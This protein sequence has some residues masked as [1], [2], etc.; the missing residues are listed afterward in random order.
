MSKPVGSLPVPPACWMHKQRSEKTD[1][2]F[3]SALRTKGD[4]SRRWI[5]IEGTSIC[6]GK[7]RGTKEKV[8]PFEVIRAVQR[9]PAAKVAGAPDVF[10]NFAWEMTLTDKIVAFVCESAETRDQ[11]VSYMTAVLDAMSGA[12]GG[13]PSSASGGG[14]AASSPATVASAG[15]NSGGGTTMSARMADS[16]SNLARGADRD[17]VVGDDEAGGATARKSAD[18]LKNLVG[19]S[20][21]ADDLDLGGAASIDFDDDFLDSDMEDDDAVERERA[22]RF[23]GGEDA[24]AEGGGGLNAE[25]MEARYRKFLLPI[26]QRSFNH[27]A[28]RLDTYKDF[29]AKWDDVVAD[30]VFS[31]TMEKIGKKDRGAE[32]DIFVT[33][34]HLFLFSKGNMFGRIADPRV[35]DLDQI[36][37]V[38]ESK[39]D[40]SLFA[41]II[42]SF[43]DL[44]L[45]VTSASS[46]VGGTEVEVKHQLIAHLYAGS[47]RLAGDTRPFIFRESENIKSLIRRSED[48]NHLPLE[49]GAFDRLG[50]AL[51][52]QLYPIFRVN[53]D[54]VVHFSGYVQRTNAQKSQSARI[55]AITDSAVYLTPT[56]A[57]R[58]NSRTGLS[59]IRRIVY[60]DDA[61]ELLLVNAD[62]DVL[63]TAKNKAELDLIV[64]V[65][66]DVAVPR[67]GGGAAARSALR[68][69]PGKQLFSGARLMEAKRIEDHLQRGIQGTEQ[70]LRKGMKLSQRMLQHTLRLG[71][72]GATKLGMGVKSIGKGS[73]GILKTGITELGELVVDNRISAGILGA[74][75]GAAGQVLGLQ[76]RIVFDMITSLEDE[77]ATVDAAAFYRKAT[78]AAGGR[79]VTLPGAAKPKAPPP[80]TDPGT[81]SRQLVAAAAQPPAAAPTPTP[82]GAIEP[83]DPVG[84]QKTSVT[85]R[86]GRVLFSC[87]CRI[88]NITAHIDTTRS[89]D[90]ILC[91]ADNGLYV[92]DDPHSKNRSGLRKIAA[93]FTSSQN[94]DVVES[95]TWSELGGIIRCVHPVDD[96]IIGVLYEENRTSGD[97]MFRLP[98][99]RVTDRFLCYASVQHWR[100]HPCSAGSSNHDDDDED[101]FNVRLPKLFTC[102]HAET[103]K[104]ALKKT[105]FDAP[106][107]I[108]LIAEGQGDQLRLGGESDVADIMRQYGDRFVTFSGLGRQL[109]ASAIRGGA[110]ASTETKRKKKKKKKEGDD[111]AGDGEDA[112]S[113]HDPI[114]KPC[115]VLVTNAAVYVVKPSFELDRR[116]DVNAI[117]RITISRDEADTLLLH[118]KTEYDVFLRMPGRMQELIDR[119]QDSRLAWSSYP[120]ELAIAERTRASLQRISQRRQRERQHAASGSRRFPSAVNL[121]SL[122]ALAAPPAKEPFLIP[123]AR[124]GG[125]SGDAATA[126]GSKVSGAAAGLMALGKLEKPANFDEIERSRRGP[127]QIEQTYRAWCSKELKKA[128]ASEGISEDGELQTAPGE[129]GTVVATINARLAPHEGEALRRERRVAALMTQLKRAYRIG[130]RDMP[131]V[132]QV[133]KEISLHD[134]RE[135]VSERLYR[136]L[137]EDD[138]EAY[139]DAVAASFDLRDGL[140]RLLDS[141][142]DDV[143]AMK[144]RHDV[145][146]RIVK[147]IALD[148]LESRLHDIA[149]LFLQA[150][151]CNVR[152]D[153]LDHLRL[154]VDRLLQRERLTQQIQSLRRVSD[155]STD[156][157]AVW[158]AAAERLGVP[159][160]VRG[161]I[162]VVGS[163]LIRW[164]ETAL[165]NAIASADPHTIEATMA[166]V[167]REP[168][169]A[170]GAQEAL[171]AAQHS[172]DL[173]RQH[174]ALITRVREMCVD[175]SSRM[176]DMTPEALRL[177]HE[178]LRGLVPKFPADTP[179]FQRPRATVLLHLGKAEHL[180]SSAEQ[181]R[182]ADEAE[183]SVMAAYAKQ[184]ELAAA[185]QQRAQ[186]QA[187]QEEADRQSAK[188][189]DRLLNIASRS[190]KYAFSVRQQVANEDTAGAH[191]SLNAIEQLSSDLAGAVDAL[192]PQEKQDLKAE[193]EKAHNT[194]RSSS[195][196]CQALM[197]KAAQAK[198]K[199]QM[200]PELAAAVRELRTQDVIQYLQK[201]QGTLPVDLIDSVKEALHREAAQAKWVAGLHHGI[202][203]AVALRSVDLLRA[204]LDIAKQKSYSDAAVH[205][206]REW[207]DAQVAAMNNAAGAAAA[208]ASPAV[209]GGSPQA[210]PPPQAALPPPAEVPKPAV[211]PLMHP[212]TTTTGKGACVLALHS[213]VV[214]LVTFPR[215]TVSQRVKGA[216]TTPDD[217]A[218]V[219]A[220][221]DAWIAALCH[222]AKPQGIFRKTDRSLADII[223]FMGE[224]KRGGD[225]VAPF[226]FYVTSE[227]ERIRKLN[228]PHGLTSAQVFVRFLMSK[229]D[230]ERLVEEIARF[231]PKE[232]DGLYF[233][234]ALMRAVAESERKDVRLLAKML[235]QIDV[236]FGL[237]DKVD[238]AVLGSRQT[239]VAGTGGATATNSAS[240]VLIDAVSKGPGATA[241]GTKALPSDLG[242]LKAAILDH[243]DDSRYLQAAGVIVF[244]QLRRAVSSLSALVTAEMR[245]LGDRPGPT[246]LYAFFDENHNKSIGVFARSNLCAA[247]IVCLG[248]GFRPTHM[249][250]ASRHLWDLFE[251]GAERLKESARGLGGVAVPDMIDMVRNLTE[252]HE[253]GPASPSHSAASRGGGGGPHQ[254]LARLS[255][256]ELNDVRVRMVLCHA[257]NHKSLEALFTTLF[258]AS[259][260]S[261]AFL[262]KFYVYDG[263]LMFNAAMRGEFDKVVRQLAKIP[264]VLNVDA[265]IW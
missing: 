241:A 8:I 206:A 242:G 102:D 110:E 2:G 10:V 37:G 105:A 145:T 19:G 81:S 40:A 155:L 235:T 62:I 160:A 49:Q 98:N 247:L 11:W 9:I 159:V 196:L 198:Q 161:S 172:L 209:E 101:R 264:F 16:S 222:R 56:S 71:L 255:S 45:R 55:F 13:V 246:A 165:S 34:K 89:E 44:L 249:L 217:T 133:K 1:G 225:V 130:C 157:R 253:R 52:S 238:A 18:E 239:S 252:V 58:I 99:G 236:S 114:T 168:E 6:Y 84:I 194:L 60:D 30:V 73:V 180:L 28:Y 256:T 189:R 254:A 17:T 179:V 7:D 163:P 82:R 66:V 200:P 164:A 244:A 41:V 126:S 251:A 118:V 184:L 35:I 137:D 243:P 237:V 231:T 147:E 149:D 221:V 158:V 146:N 226:I 227:F 113:A 109:R 57:D 208:A 79:M 95:C 115:V 90:V 107:K 211:F 220:V 170:A 132:A 76:Q 26:A 83:Y 234:D 228:N 46:L 69:T 122:D 64:K 33:R 117:T 93:A 4:F 195:Q 166:T 169:A 167:N 202:H 201:N 36:V 265:E 12:S 47:S 61:K 32:R 108:G 97:L 75:E 39:I 210:A 53:A 27:I 233:E 139:D 43:H 38:I 141:Q 142:L 212:W 94:F 176:Y 191:S 156:A 262:A 140:Q 59:D 187:A 154:E 143:S 229:R 144:Q 205:G 203:T 25:S 65:L 29:F 125:G 119:M 153:R 100:Y 261:K 260:S 14:G 42:P 138:A 151:S 148:G 150:E 207:L 173:L 257:M 177:V 67:Q 258:D 3:F 103:V 54:N 85:A 106:P 87:R 190:A 80:P 96:N 50:V 91:I 171:S 219:R 123:I 216:I 223:Q 104:L 186:Q 240:N 74:V 22:K 121:A 78:A 51:N 129:P 193:C 24:S 48:D 135:T 88:Y 232:L 248:I 124:G 127:R 230:L 263:A 162:A 199:R 21:E 185:E 175:L 224:V 112:S 181:R 70:G 68:P 111:N 92:L 23:G 192:T 77:R 218:E 120:V 128:L 86:I 188:R 131:Q 215:N 136:A 213:A 152:A 116:I 182:K 250:F 259:A 31:R 63:V 174:D 183:V 134:E 20:G 245:R 72:A 204:Q 178:E 5:W 15:S 197:A 214:A